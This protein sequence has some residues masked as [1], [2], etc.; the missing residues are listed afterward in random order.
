MAVPTDAVLQAIEEC[1]QAHA[2]AAVILTGGF[3]EVGD[4]GR[5]LQNRVIAAARAGGVRLIGPN[6]FG[7]INAHAG[8]N[9]SIGIGLP[10]AGA[11][12]LFTQ[13]GAYGM[14]AFSRSKEEGIGFA[15]VIAPGNKADLDETE[16]VTYLGN[17][18]DTRVIAML[19]ES[20]SDGAAFLDAVRAVTSVKPVIVLKTGRNKTAQRAA[21]SHTAALAGDY[22]ITAAALRQAG[23]RLVEDGLSL[24]DVAAALA[25]Q[26]PLH[27]NRIAIITN[28]GGTGVELTDLL[29]DEGLA[30][31]Q[32]SQAL[33]AKIRKFIPAYGS[34]G[35]P[36]R[37][38]DRL[39]AL[40][41]DVW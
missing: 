16:I 6:C 33:Q 4:E 10:T 18:P 29:E 9:A 37:C 25:S 19:L 17:D 2:K 30:V 38:H 40:C 13:S 27:G 36:S 23:V 8:L 5:A 11:V 41:A 22:R 31:P 34:A 35:N 7:V 3:A 15:K 32:L 24:L 20:I 26:P 12:S 1:A 28:S 39:A 21:A 14:A